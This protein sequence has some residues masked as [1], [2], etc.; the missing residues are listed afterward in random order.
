MEI[1][2]TRYVKS[3]RF[4]IAYQVLG[5]GPFDLVFIPSASSHVE[6]RWEEPSLAKAYRRIAS[7]SRLI[8]FD[9]RGTGLSDRALELPILEEQMD[10]VLAVMEAAGSERAALF[11]IV[12]GGALAMLFAATY[13]DRTSALITYGTTSKWLADSDYPWGMTSEMW[14]RLESSF[15]EQ[16]GVDEILAILAPSRVRDDQFKA[17]LGRYMRLGAGPGGLLAVMRMM[18]EVDVRHVLP[19]IRVP[20]LVLHREGDGL[21]NVENARYLASNVPG[22]KL[23]ELPGNDAMFWAGNLDE[24]VDEIQEFLTG[25]RPAPEPDRVLATMLFTDIVDSTKRAAE[26][27]DRRWRELMADHDGI[28]R[29]EL[30]AQRGR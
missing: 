14:S 2:E 24:L 1:P 11:G 21:V 29:Q 19:V 3:G 27:G 30:L 6:V 10:D 23:V 22:A 13:P 9:K 18:A 8:M 16:F 5:E 26:L 28:V 7:F 15:D 20:T 25:V 17:W 4:H 12:D